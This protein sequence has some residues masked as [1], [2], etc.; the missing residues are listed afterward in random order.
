MCQ[1]SR[2]KNKKKYVG[3]H[4]GGLINW[5][6]K[7]RNQKRLQSEQRKGSPCTSPHQN[8]K[9]CTARDPVRNRNEIC[10]LCWIDHGTAC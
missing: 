10:Q 9:R 5:R 7:P 8:E 4:S 3:K 6:R 1:G 2:E